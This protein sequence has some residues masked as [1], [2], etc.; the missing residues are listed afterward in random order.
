MRVLREAAVVGCLTHDSFVRRVDLALQAQELSALEAV[1]ADLPSGGTRSRF[2]ALRSRIL[3]VGGPVRSAG[4]TTRAAQLRLPRDRRRDHV[5]GRS[6]RCDLAVDDPSVSRVHA[7]LRCF[8]DQWFVVD[9]G[10]TNGTRVN[11]LRVSGTLVLEPGDLVAFGQA[12]FRVEPATGG[13]HA[14]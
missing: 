8:G 5:V 6:R 1:T 4:P 7:A 9:L 13:G 3:P 10:S 2:R 12:V 14:G 11:G